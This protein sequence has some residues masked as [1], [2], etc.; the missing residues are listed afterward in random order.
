[1]HTDLRKLTVELEEKAEADLAAAT[2]ERHAYLHGKLFTSEEEFIPG[3]CNDA[4][5]KAI[6]DGF[7]KKKPK[8]MTDNYG[9]RHGDQGLVDYVLGSLSKKFQAAVKASIKAHAA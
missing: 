5:I 3:V 6:K 9:V 1:M 4:E 2:V 7:G 8:P